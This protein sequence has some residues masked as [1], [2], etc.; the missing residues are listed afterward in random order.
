MSSLVSV[1]IPTYD[2]RGYVK[3]AVESVLAQTYVDYEA[4]LVENGGDR[5]AE[6]IVKALD[7][8]RCHYVHISEANRGLARN[9]GVRESSGEYLAFLDDDDRFL[10]EKL[11]IQVDYLETHL[12]VGLVAGGLMRI[13]EDGRPINEWLLWKGSP[14]L[15]FEACIRDGCHLQFGAMLMRRE[16]FD[17]VGGI[18]TELP[19]VQDTDFFLR[20]ML[21]G[22]RMDWLKTIVAEYRMHSGSTQDAVVL[23][24]ECRQQML[25]KLFARTELPESVRAEKDE[26]C[27]THLATDVGRCYVA[28]EKEAGRRLL[29]RALVLSNEDHQEVF[30]LVTEAIVSTSSGRGVSDCF[31][32]S[33]KALALVTQDL[34]LPANLRWSALAKA[35][36]RDFYAGWKAGD[37]GQVVG[38]F[39]R[40]A[41]RQPSW[42]INRGSWSILARSILGMAPRDT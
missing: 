37:L 29:E 17:R 24:A 9:V 39:L 7:D 12:D 28:Q 27:L 15:T 32:A 1:I 21:A 13:D 42:L 3:E 34:E 33:R 10:P 38:S 40:A 26:I 30:Q 25:A 36:Q 11:E 6:E 4:I 23:R 5:N 19:L 18:S 41:V 22:C 35:A 16:W 31:M 14:Q 8:S 20:L 2:R